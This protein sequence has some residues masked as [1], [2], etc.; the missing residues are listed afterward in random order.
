HRSHLAL[1]RA[2]PHH[3][4]G[5]P[6]T[7]DAIQL[8]ASPAATTERLDARARRALVLLLAATFVTFLNETL[9]SVAIPDIMADLRVSASTGQWLTTAFALTMAGVIPTTGWLLQRFSTRTLF[10][11]AM[12][13]F[14]AGTLLAALRSEERRVGQVCR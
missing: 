7:T 14:A 8:P 10:V 12:T 1:I 2:A 5:D 11:G 3:H 13:L 6:V 4:H 9:M